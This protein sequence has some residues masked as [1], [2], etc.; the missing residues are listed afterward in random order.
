M[1]DN[2]HTVR[3]AFV[4]TLKAKVRQTS[5]LNRNC[6]IKSIINQENN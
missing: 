3:L 5:E 6:E 2:V 1:G 4:I